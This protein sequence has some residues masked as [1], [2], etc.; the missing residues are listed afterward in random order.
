M[1][2]HN[3]ILL[4]VFSASALLVIPAN[5]KEYCKQGVDAIECLTSTVEVWLP[6]CQRLATGE[7]ELASAGGSQEPKKYVECIA[8][9][10]ADVQALYT[11]A[12]PAAKR[13]KTEAALREYSAMSLAAFSG[14]NPGPDEPN[15]AYRQRQAN[16]LQALRVQGERVK[17]R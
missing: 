1:R 8:Q 7:F 6:L 16:A 10:R 4:I 5:A 14:I 12:L 2:P 15:I 11:Q 17:L 13:N 3:A 9:A